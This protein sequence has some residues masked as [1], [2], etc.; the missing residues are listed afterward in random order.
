MEFV[1]L[2]VEDAAGRAEAVVRLDHIAY[3]QA[4]IRKGIDGPFDCGVLYLK[5]GERLRVVDDLD[6]FLAKLGL[7][8]PEA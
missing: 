1:Q 3:Y 5:S 2:T 7:E 4:D 6:M 8:E